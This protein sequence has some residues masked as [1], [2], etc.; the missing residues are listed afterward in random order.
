MKKDIMTRPLGKLHL[1]WLRSFAKARTGKIAV[2][3][4]EGL[5]LGRAYATLVARGLL[6]IDS[7]FENGLDILGITDAG[8][9]ALE[10]HNPEIAREAR[11]RIPLQRK[12]EYD[13]LPAWVRERRKTA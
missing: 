1:Y 13:R 3:G 6:G 9:D 2:S 8:L 11:V 12:A 7:Q 5:P 10:E 4:Y